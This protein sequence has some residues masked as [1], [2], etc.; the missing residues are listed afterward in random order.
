MAGWGGQLWDG[1]KREKQEVAGKGLKSGGSC[2]T[3][4]RSDGNQDRGVVMRTQ[5]SGWAPSSRGGDPAGSPGA[6]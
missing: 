4:M 2:G 6:T 3:S 5:G 1:G